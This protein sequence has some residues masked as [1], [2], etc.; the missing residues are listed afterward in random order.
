MSNEKNYMQDY[1]KQTSKTILFEQF[2]KEDQAG[3]IVPNL[4]MLLSKNNVEDDAFY[5]EVIDKL[6]VR[7][8]KSFVDKFLP[9]VYENVVIDEN[10]G[11]YKV[12]YSLTRPAGWDDDQLPIGLDSEEFYQMIL[13]LYERR[14]ES[15]KAKIEFDYDEVSKLICPVA[16]RERYQKVRE[17]LQYNTE[18]FLRLEAD[19]PGVPSYEKDSCR[20]QIREAETVMNGVLENGV[21]K[22]LPLQLADAE[23]VLLGLGVK[24]DDDSP[25][26]IIRGYLTYDGTGKIVAKKIESKGETQQDNSDTGAK[27]M[28]QDR[29]EKNYQKNAP[30]AI[31]ESTVLQTAFMRTFALSE[32][33]EFDKSDLIDMVNE[34]QDKYKELTE[35]LAFTIA[36]VVEKFI[37]V[38]AFFDN[39]SQNG[40]MEDAGLI[41]TNCSARD[42][43]IDDGIREALERFLANVNKNRK[44]RIWFGILPAIALGIEEKMVKGGVKQSSSPFDD[45]D[46]EEPTE[47]ML[48]LV[49][50]SEAEK[51]L[52]LCSKEDIRIMTFFNFKANDKTVFG[53]LS[54]ETVNKMK[55]KIN[56]NGCDDQGAHA[57]C[58]LPNFTIYPKGNPVMNQ[59]LYDKGIQERKKVIAIPGVYV[60]AAYVAAGMTV[61]TQQMDTI[62]L[63]VNKM[64]TGIRIDFEE[65]D[66]W[67]N[68]LA[69]M[70]RESLLGDS[71]AVRNLIMRDRFGF[72]FNDEEFVD[73]EGRIKTKC[74]VENARTMCKDETKYTKI[75]YVLL[76][77]F[78]KSYLGGSG[79]NSKI[80][81]FINED[82]NSWKR[83][84]QDQEQASKKIVNCLLKEGEQISTNEDG[85]AVT[86]N[87][88]NEYVRYKVNFKK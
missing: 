69:N 28:I 15:G 37:G 60:E 36:P 84:L 50:A 77:D 6:E 18:E 11:D 27:K 82:V 16:A 72:Y 86:L 65:K 26:K 55:N 22:I 21:M 52:Q 40:R 56:F 49:S 64:L 45:D 35:E 4:A 63:N 41:V 19:N 13:N 80:Q 71:I 44:E 9:F 12:S 31:R 57:V 67:Q 78:I 30:L 3:S 85:I 10:T 43:I 33:T 47:E 48:K 42:L 29:L 81:E 62:P 25:D 1:F 17:R 58:C 23:N 66:I 7:D 32:V 34:C 2:T 51:L 8:F 75:N 88:D 46:E 68:Y 54:E 24:K 79:L 87:R 39:V 61:G 20:Q 70:C 53:S 74:H 59:E 14:K 76:G 83:I 5:K 38:K 73:S